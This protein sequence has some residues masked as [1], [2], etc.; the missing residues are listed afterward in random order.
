MAG[1][2]AT[3]EEAA[4]NLYEALLS[5][6]RKEANYPFDNDLMAEIEDLTRKSGLVRMG[7][8]ALIPSQLVAPLG[9]AL[10]TLDPVGFTAPRA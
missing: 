3:A 6:A 5:E 7:Q 2:E 1:T 10:R 4:G 9:Q 8:E